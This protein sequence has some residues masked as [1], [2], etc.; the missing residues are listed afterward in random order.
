MYSNV[1]TLHDLNEHSQTGRHVV[2][3]NLIFWDVKM[4]R[5][6]VE[7]KPLN[8]TRYNLHVFKT[9]SVFYPLFLYLMPK[10]I[11]ICKAPN[12]SL[13]DSITSLPLFEAVYMQFLQKCQ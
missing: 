3:L 1:P 7:L 11:F 12:E 6:Y 10:C 4:A 5:L 8:D 2:K 13:L 9:S